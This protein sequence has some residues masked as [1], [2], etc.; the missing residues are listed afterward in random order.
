MATGNRSV[1]VILDSRR[2]AERRGADL[3]VCAA[4]DHFGVA[5]EVLDSGDYWSIA[6]PHV[7]DRAAFLLA[8]DGAGAGLRPEQAA[9]IGEAVRAGAGLLSFDRDTGNWPDGIRELA[10][11]ASGS[12][13]LR[14]IGFPEH[15]HPVTAG[16]APGET[17]T[18]PGETT[19]VCFDP[20]GATVPARAGN[21]VPALVILQR[22]KGRC[23]FFAVG[24]TLYDDMVLGHTRGLDGLFWRGLAWVAVKPFPMRCI[25]PYVSARMDDCNGTYSSFRYVRCMNRHGVRPN[26]GLFLDELGPTDW[27]AAARLHRQGGADFSMHAFRDDLYKASPKWQP[28]QPLADKPDLSRGGTHVRFEG[29]GVD[30]AS[31]RDLDDATVRANFARVDAAFAR[32]GIRHS[33]VLNAHFGEIGLSSLPLFLERGWDLPCNNSVAGQLYGSQPVWRPRPYGLRAVNGRYGL[34]IDRLPQHP[35][36]L[37]VGF[38]ASHLGRTHMTSDVL[39]GHTPFLGEAAEVRMGDAIRRGVANVRV[40]LDSLAFGVIM[41]HEQRIHA[42]ALPQ[43]ETIFDGIMAGLADLDP[44][45]ESREQISLVCRRLFGTRLSF[46]HAGPDGLLCEITGVADG[47]SPLTVWT[48]DGATLSARRTEIPAVNSFLRLTVPD[49]PARHA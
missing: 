14:D 22:G 33:R 47:P 34:V 1:L 38:S 46:A 19:A 40:G 42:I 25:P 2:V 28:F 41:T 27:D 3:T 49:S 20:D 8:H 4:L 7:S 32:A 37:S 15:R 11:A 35:A 13:T 44:L 17:V 6:R 39:S 30:H 21:G 43:W 45:P 9:W 16:H 23:L 26:L 29:L 12:C 31:G 36:F 18:L 48:D 24:N 5:W 10:P